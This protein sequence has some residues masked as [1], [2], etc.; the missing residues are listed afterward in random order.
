MLDYRSK[1]PRFDP[2]PGHGDFFKSPVTNAHKQGENV[3]GRPSGS[4]AQLA[5]C[6]HGGFE[7]RSGHDFFLPCDI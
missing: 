7:S 3:K 6:S 2:R 1:G 5:E 4:V